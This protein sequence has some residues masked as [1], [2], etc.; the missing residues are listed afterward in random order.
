VITPLHARK[1][2]V[3]YV[4]LFFVVQNN[5][6]LF[7]CLEITMDTNNLLRV[8][9]ESMP[10]T[11]SALLTPLIAILAIYIA[12]RQY[13]VDHFRFKHETYERRL[14]VYKAIQSFLSEI[15]SEAYVPYKRVMQF[16]ADTSEA[17]FLF[18]KPIPDY[19]DNMHSKAIDLE[20]LH[21]KMYPRD[22]SDGLPIGQERNKVDHDKAEILE[23]FG[24]QCLE[25]KELFKKQMSIEDQSQLSII[26]GWIS[27]KVL[28]TN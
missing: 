11:L 1:I 2:L 16:Y 26:C 22:G 6:K 27:K 14:R 23:W 24:K 8:S 15:I 18:K 4:I 7:G 10:W 5:I 28:H 19:I 20:A 12:Y 25:S 21:E 13:R 17:V 3:R 9:I